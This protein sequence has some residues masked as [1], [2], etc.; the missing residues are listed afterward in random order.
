MST[1][2]AST[3]AAGTDSGSFLKN[4]GLGG[5][6][7]SSLLRRCR[8]FL[9]P[10][11][12]L[13]SPNGVSYFFARRASRRG[14]RHAAGWRAR[15]HRLPLGSALR[16]RRPAEGG[17]APGRARPGHCPRTRGRRV[18][19]RGGGG[20]RSSSAGGD[21]TA[22][23]RRRCVALRPRSLCARG[24]P[25]S[26]HSRGFQKSF[27]RTPSHSLVFP[28]FTYLTKSPVTAEIF[29]RL[30]RKSTRLNSSH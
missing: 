1:R 29:L 22:R 8:L 15:L 11:Q 28:F 18:P 26:L 10:R 24:R 19:L 12:S 16:S 27:V 17:A 2:R 7:S 13:L 23:R 3:K 30:D 6:F 5:K 25:P 20:A 21:P 9:R 14:P 4:E